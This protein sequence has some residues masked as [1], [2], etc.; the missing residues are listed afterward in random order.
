MDSK[1]IFVFTDIDLDGATSLLGLH[2]ALNAKPGELQFKAVTVSN[3]RKEFLL[4]AAEDSIENY[5]AVYFLD[6][7][8]SSCAD[9][10]DNKK[11]VIIDHHSSHVQAKDKYKNAVTNIVETTSCAKLIYIHFKN[12]LSNITN[13]QKYLFALANDYDSYTLKLKES[14]ELNC[15]YTNTQKTLE[16]TRV[17]KFV[18]RYYEGFKGFN[19]QEKNV[20]KEHITARDIAINTL[21][22]FSGTVNIS[23]Q[24]WVVTGA[25]GTKFVNEICEHL[26]KTYSSD[27]VFFINT[28]NSHVSFRKKK[29]CPVNLSKLAEKLCG[30][31]GHEYAAG[32]KITETFM[33][34]TKQL[35]PLEK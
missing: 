14:Y 25:M 11:S 17:H 13:E 35:T 22:V 2:W 7:D 20:I 33:E 21:N 8:T 10:I 24:P 32:G 9:V 31:G 28:N 16:K 26:I 3:F 23:K 1:R 15:T 6:L 19:Q 27:I 18:E 29:D 30:G 5:D 4:W 12:E 34:F